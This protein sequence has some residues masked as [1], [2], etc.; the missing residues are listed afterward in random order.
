MYKIKQSI[1]PSHILLPLFISWLV[2]LCLPACSTSES[3]EEDQTIRETESGETMTKSSSEISD[4]KSFSRA[5]GLFKSLFTK[6]DVPD[7]GMLPFGE[8][9]EEDLSEFFPTILLSYNLVSGRQIA[10]EL[11]N[12]YHYTTA[13]EKEEESVM[14]SMYKFESS[15]KMLEFFMAIDSIY[16]DDSGLLIREIK[17][18]DYE[19]WEVL[20]S[21]GQRIEVCLVLPNTRLIQ[22]SAGEIFEGDLIELL[23]ELELRKL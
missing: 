18:M 11:Q 21:D 9:A 3:S 10:K 4:H 23:S 15:L 16:A 19:G 8:E 1:C 6:E 20:D 2:I 22:G 13:Y 17:V 14:F 5:T 12:I 7:F